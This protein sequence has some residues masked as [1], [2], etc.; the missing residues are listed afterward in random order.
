MNKFSQAW[1]FNSNSIQKILTDFTVTTCN[2]ITKVFYGDLCISEVESNEKTL[3]FQ[4]DGFRNIL[5]CHMKN[6]GIKPS[7]VCFDMRGGQ[8]EFKFIGNPIHVHGFTFF[9]Y[10]TITDSVD[11]SLALQMNFGLKCKETDGIIMI[12]YNNPSASN[13]WRHGKITFQERTENIHEALKSFNHS[14]ERTLNTLGRFK[15]KKISYRSVVSKLADYDDNNKLKLG[16]RQKLI[17]LNRQIRLKHNIKDE[18]LLIALRTPESFISSHLDFTIQAMD[19]FLYC[20]D[21]YKEQNSSA[22]MRE[23][24]RIIQIIFTVF[25][26][27]SLKNN[28]EYVFFEKTGIPFDKFYKEHFGKLAWSLN[29]Y[30]KNMELAEDFAN[31]TFVHGLK[32][33]DTFDP[34][35]AK[36]NTWLYKIGENLVRKG[37]KDDQKLPVVSLDYPRKEDLT[38]LNII[39]NKES[40][41]DENM[42][43]ERKAEIIRDAIYGLPPKYEKYK[44][45]L[46]M[47][48][49][50]NMQ[51]Q[52]ISE[53]TG[54]N[55]NTVKSQIVKGRDI[56]IKKVSKQFSIIDKELMD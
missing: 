12:D 27:S 4:S 46:I 38:L 56:I 25:E 14:T 17:A 13:R 33:I 32:K 16:N 52:E 5:T 11:G 47:R 39:P 36:M 7:F 6:Y 15:D 1:S 29:K 3:Y 24:N 23:N 43:I 37:Y 51:Y 53:K 49:L 9:E 40:N 30:T 8:Y 22:I 35:I 34:T 54:I 10:I 31:E 44:T 45:V 50:D 55:L 41:G 26:E 18:N 21:A 28:S 42:I 2:G 48:E 19:L 20:I